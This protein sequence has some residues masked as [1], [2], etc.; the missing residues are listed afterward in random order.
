MASEYADIKFEIKG[1]IGIIKFNRPKAL[2]SFG[3]NLIPDVIAALRVLNEHPETVFTVLTGEGRFFSAGADVKGISDMSAEY[4]NAGEKKLAFLRGFTYAIELLRS[5]IDHTKVLVLA[6]NG[7]G[8]G[9][10]AAW[11]PGIADI[12][13]ASSTA[14]LQCPFS[15]LGLVPENGSALSFAQH[16]GIHRTN[17]FLMFGTKLSAQELLD[18]GMY[19]RVWEKTGD[20]FQSEVVRFLEGQL[21]VNDGKSMMEMKRLQ[22]AP[23]RDARMMAVVNAVDAL[24]ERFVEDAPVRRFAEKKRAMEEKSKARAKM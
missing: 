2:N 16:I 24:A 20:A 13:L 6:L 17:D 1:K 22:N 9:G 14:W 5:M 4:K 11:F 3:G 10:G 12:V 19:N 21:E 18:C 23:V 7:P 8:V 15:A